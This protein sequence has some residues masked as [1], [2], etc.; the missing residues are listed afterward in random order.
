M[1]DVT[2][3]RHISVAA[4]HS[5]IA[6]YDGLAFTHYMQGL[7]VPVPVQGDTMHACTTMSVN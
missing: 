3:K 6:C 4:M 7:V 2:T 1:I 5:Y